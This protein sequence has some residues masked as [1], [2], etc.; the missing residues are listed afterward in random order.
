ML[1]GRG[2]KIR[3]G[4]AV[5]VVLGASGLLFG[6]ASAAGAAGSTSP[7]SSGTPTSCS[8]S[9]TI[10]VT[11]TPQTVSLG[12]TCAFSPNS[13]VTVSYQGSTVATVT[14]D[15]SGLV[16]L[17]ITATDPH[18]AINGGTP[19]TAVFGTNTITASG[20][21]SSGASNTATFLVDLQAAPATSSSTT[22]GS[23]GGLAF[24]GADLAALIAAALALVLF[25]TGVVLYTRRRRDETEVPTPSV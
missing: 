1:Q 21:N 18:L 11:N 25:G 4:G 8:T 5:A 15:S 19:Q 13:S 20:T 7:S 14:S 9:T 17:S 10:T 23:T 16:T 3:V 22:S 6:A 2:T 24:T 12:E